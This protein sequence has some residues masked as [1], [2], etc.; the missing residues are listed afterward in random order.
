[1]DVLE[2]HEEKRQAVDETN[3][4]RPFA[5]QVA[6]DP[7]LAHAQKVIG[8]RILEVED[9]QSRLLERSFLVS[10]RNEDAVLF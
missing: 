2:L 7:K 9:P 4:V 3:Y 10:V 8:L 1:V 5:T 6:L